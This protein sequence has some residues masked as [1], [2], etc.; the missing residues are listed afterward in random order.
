[1][2]RKWLIGLWLS[3]ACAMAWSHGD[4]GQAENSAQ[5]AQTERARIDSLREKKTVELDAEDAACLSKFAVTD[6]QNQVGV[7]R[8]QM[9]SELKAQDAVLND[10]ER[11]QK[12]EDQLKQGQAKE[13]E[14]RQRQLEAQATAEKLGLEDRQQ[15]QSNKQRAHQQQAQ[16]VRSRASA[17]KFG[18]VLD[19]QTIQKNRQ[20]YLEKQK[21]FE[22]RR[23]ER[24]QRVMDAG[25][26]VPPLPLAP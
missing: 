5:A 23:Q 15:S 19:A 13:V 12:G 6:C 14:N 22:K 18:P 4:P 24:D 3:G 2:T 9:L 26:G 10:A 8:R 20:A 25:K 17:A 1:M 7:R 16:T 21:A 11:L